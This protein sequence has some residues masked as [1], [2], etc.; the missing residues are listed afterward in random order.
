MSE[1]SQSGLQAEP[2][3]VLQPLYP[4]PSDWATTTTTS[5]PLPARV[6]PRSGAGGMVRRAGSHSGP[7]GPRGCFLYEQRLVQGVCSA[8]CHAS[9]GDHRPGGS[10]GNE[11]VSWAPFPLQLA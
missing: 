11:L 9:Q 3:Q 4:M 2:T 6:F 1:M 8:H 5:M 10:T 7:L